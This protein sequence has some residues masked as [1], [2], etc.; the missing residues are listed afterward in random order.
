MR[1]NATD[2]P[3][4]P[5][6]AE[7]AAGLHHEEGPA[8]LLIGY[9]NLL[10]SDD[11]VGPA[12]VSRLAASFFDNPDCVTI[13]THQL[14]PE[15]AVDVARA[16]RVVFVDASVDLPAGKA[17]VRRVRPVSSGS[18]PLGHHMSPEAVLEL[19]RTVFGGGEGVGGEGGGGGT[20]KAWVVAVGVSNLSVGDRLSPPVS[21]TA[22]RLSRHLAHRIRRWSTRATAPEGQVASKKGS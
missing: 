18:H 14:T 19:A 2:I 8:V 3:S 12:V 20:P 17:R 5:Q 21:R 9:G 15:L 10:R 22:G 13:T 6:A 4:A 1:C 11:G 7:A 16:Q